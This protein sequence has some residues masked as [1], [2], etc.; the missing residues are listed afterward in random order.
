MR[1]S[2]RRHYRA[3]KAARKGTTL[4]QSVFSGTVSSDFL[5][6]EDGNRKFWP[7]CST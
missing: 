1:W 2:R 4:K 3:R 6:D 7:A 5:K